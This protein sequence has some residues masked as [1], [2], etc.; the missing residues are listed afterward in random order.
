ML[1]KLRHSRIFDT[2]P[3][4]R[5]SWQYKVD[6]NMWMELWKR[7]KVL[8]YTVPEIV[9]YF[10]LKT[11]KDITTRQVKKWIFLTEVFALTKP[12]RE[13]RAEV[14]DTSLFGKLEKKVI[15]EITRSMKFCGVKRSNIIL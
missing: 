6:E 5:F 3:T 12:A 10:Q 2:D 15:V 8:D 7:Y 1:V 14:F 13:K 9:E 4:R 11:G